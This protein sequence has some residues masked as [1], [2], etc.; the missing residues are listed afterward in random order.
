MVLI[1]ST[2]PDDNAFIFVSSFVKISHRVPELS[3]GY[4]FQTEIYKGA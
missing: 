1:F 3:G 2:L 4:D